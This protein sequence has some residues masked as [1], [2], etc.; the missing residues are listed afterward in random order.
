MAAKPAATPNPTQ[1]CATYLCER[2]SN[3]A[4][5]I[6]TTAHGGAHGQQRLEEIDAQ[7]TELCI[8]FAQFHNQF[9][10]RVR[11]LV[12]AVESVLVLRVS[13]E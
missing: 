5:T 1:L 7:F 10:E 13:A 4:S 6:L 12:Y 8:I 3:G 11:V 9:R 2:E